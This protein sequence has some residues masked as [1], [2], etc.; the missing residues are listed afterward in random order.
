M[1]FIQLTEAMDNATTR[2]LVINA[3]HVKYFNPSAR[4]ADTYIKLTDGTFFFVKE[5]IEQ[6]AQKLNDIQS[7]PNDHS[8]FYSYVTWLAI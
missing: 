5:R 1:K 7:K 6:I 4:G 8:L 3:D 2:Q